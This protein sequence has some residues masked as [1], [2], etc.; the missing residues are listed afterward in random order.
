ML[1][2]KIAK[3]SEA[4]GVRVSNRAP[5]KQLRHRNQPQEGERSGAPLQQNGRT[6]RETN[7]TIR[8]ATSQLLRI[9][10]H[11]MATPKVGGGGEV[12]RRAN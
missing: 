10:L 2:R 8:R 11:F 5:G 7:H 12:S 1:E 4:V 6:H 3:L 9:D